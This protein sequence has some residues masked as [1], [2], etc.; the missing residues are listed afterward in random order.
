MVL[1]IFLEMKL[2]RDSWLIWVA[3]VAKFIHLNRGHVDSQNYVNTLRLNELNSSEIF[4]EKSA[5][6]WQWKIVREMNS[7]PHSVQ[8]TAGK[9]LR[10]LTE[11]KIINEQQNDFRDVGS[12]FVRSGSGR[13]NAAISIPT[14]LFPLLFVSRVTDTH[15]NRIEKRLTN[16]VQR[17]AGWFTWKIFFHLNCAEATCFLR[18][19]V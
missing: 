2:F 5:K 10:S 6:R 19:Q 4:N 18:F 8:E 15:L 7:T 16:A 13:M 17:F 11:G 14:Q 3:Q 9:D 12:L 1:S